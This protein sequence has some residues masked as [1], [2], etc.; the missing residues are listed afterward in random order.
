MLANYAFDA[1][2]VFFLILFVSMCLIGTVTG[3][4]YDKHIKQ[5]KKP[6]PRLI[7]VGCTRKSTRA[8][9]YLFMIL[10][11]WN[12]LSD[13]VNNPFL[14]NQCIGY[15]LTFYDIDYRALARK[16]DWLMAILFFGSGVLFIFFLI[17]MCFAA[18]FK[19]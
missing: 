13:R 19:L 9:G 15:K 3:N 7:A 1:M 8:S 2:S 17:L 11:R 16:R 18:Q 5:L 4:Y 6:L 10:T 14:K 12:F